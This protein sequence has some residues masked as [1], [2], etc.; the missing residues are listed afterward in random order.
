MWRRLLPY[1][2]L[3]LICLVVFGA[4]FTA[5]PPLDR[6]ESRFAQASKQMLESGD[7][8]RIQFQGEPR[9]KKP[10][11]AYWLQAASASLLGGPEKAPIWA[12]RLPSAIAA[13][14]AVLVLYGFA[15]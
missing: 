3:T 7:Y 4:G 11:G 13:W 14:L 6:D 2:A 8:V 15:S 5:L 1:L 9:N 10:A 12:Y